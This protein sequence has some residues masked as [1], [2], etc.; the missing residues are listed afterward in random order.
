M[1]QIII[2]QQ[3]TIESRSMTKYIKN[4]FGTKHSEPVSTL[5]ESSTKDDTYEKLLLSLNE[6]TKQMQEQT[7][8]F[9]E[10]QTQQQERI[11]TVARQQL[12]LSELITTNKFKDSPSSSNP[13][14]SSTISPS[15]KTQYLSHS[16]ES[17]D[18]VCV[19][20]DD[21]E[22]SPKMT[23]ADALFRLKRIITIDT[24]E[25]Y[26]IK[27]RNNSKVITSVFEKPDAERYLSLKN[28]RVASDIIEGYFEEVTIWSFIKSPSIYPK[29]VKEEITF[30]NNIFTEWKYAPIASETITDKS[31]I[32][33]P[34][35]SLLNDCIFKDEP[36][37]KQQWHLWVAN[38]VQNPGAIN[39]FGWLFS[40]KEGTGKTTLI[41]IISEMFSGYSEENVDDIDKVFGTYNKE[42]LNKVF[43]CINELELSRFAQLK[44][45]VTDSTF[46]LKISN[47]EIRT[48]QN[49]NNL[50]ITTNHV[51]SDLSKLERR[52]QL[53]YVS[54]SHA[55]DRAFFKPIYDMIANPAAMSALITYYS[56]EF[57][58]TNYIPEPLQCDFTWQTIYGQFVKQYIKARTNMKYTEDYLKT[59][60]GESF[61]R[62]DHPLIGQSILD[63]GE[64]LHSLHS[65]YTYWLIKNKINTDEISESTFKK[66]IMPYLEE[67]YVL[68]KRL[69]QKGLGNKI[70]YRFDRNKL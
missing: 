31:K 49:V 57:D 25:I 45:A 20:N 56:F 17:I 26:Y 51:F 27:R 30:Q 10:F 52:W 19:N 24:N 53:V 46:K 21:P 63:T 23:K 16:Y 29:L 61:V 47:R 3:T 34:Y 6:V 70:V 33:Q 64:T 44:S 43:I 14:L 32:L 28:I 38:I 15:K 69:P 18:D 41:K 60:W 37:L 22:S 9:K 59:Y 65:Q 2:F 42:R 67:A 62:S 1:Y 12:D 11:D 54:D 7:K 36:K 68:G 4:I 48:A 39:G 66:Y 40:G 50:C 58:L 8:S 5:N 13:S 55:R 35:F